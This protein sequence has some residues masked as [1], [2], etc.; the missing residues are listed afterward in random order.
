MAKKKPVGPPALL[1]LDLGCGDRKTEGYL[2]VDKH[3]TPSVDVVCDLTKYP[4]PWKDGAVEAIMCNHFFEHIPGKQRGIFMNECYRILKV[5][6]TMTIQGPY[7]SS[8]R[9]IQDYTHEWPPVAETSFLYFNKG[10][11]E[12]NKL[13]HYLD[14][15]CDFD[16]VYGHLLDAETTARG[17]EQRQFWVRHYANAVS[18]LSVTLTKRGQ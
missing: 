16:F 18:D 15:T 3:K 5:G 17:D 13:Q 7:W 10:W 6:G 2:G 14:A 9:S 4:W 12:Q 11:R 8:M 1:K